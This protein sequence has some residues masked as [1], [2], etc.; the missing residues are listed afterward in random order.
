MSQDVTSKVERKR[1]VFVAMDPSV[2]SSLVTLQ[3]QAWTDQGGLVHAAVCKL[4]HRN[5]QGRYVLPEDADYYEEQVAA[6]KR[7]CKRFPIA[8]DDANN[9][10]KMNPVF[11]TAGITVSEGVLRAK[12]AEAEK[13]TIELDR[14]TTKNAALEDEN[15]DLKRRLA[16]AE[17]KALGSRR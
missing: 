3:K 13:S 14:A 2:P 9:E 11:E 16:E 12:L 8:E 6:L 10:F 7:Y 5:R 15:A 4:V 17:A 1:R